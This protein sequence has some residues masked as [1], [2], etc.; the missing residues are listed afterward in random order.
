MN[1]ISR[2]TEKQLVIEF[3]S[4]ESINLLKKA[5]RNYEILLNDLE[6][7]G[8]NLIISN[9]KAELIYVNKKNY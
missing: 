2:F 4:F 9:S 1:P 5:Y 6:F 7:N 8:K 3:E